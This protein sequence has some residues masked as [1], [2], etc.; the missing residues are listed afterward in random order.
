MNL[1]FL[2]NTGPNTRKKF[3]LDSSSAGGTSLSNCGST[4][5]KDRRFVLLPSIS[6]AIVK[7]KNLHVLII[8]N[9]TMGLCCQN[10]GTLFSCLRYCMLSEKKPNII[11]HYSRYV[12]VLTAMN[13]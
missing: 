3:F 13:D 12:H 2:S 11:E 9:Q 8:K 10:R 7:E 4:L 5:S 1:E 6:Y